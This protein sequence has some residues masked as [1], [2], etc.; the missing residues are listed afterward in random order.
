M[1]NFKFNLVILIKLIGLSL[2]V[3]SCATKKDRDFQDFDSQ[4]IE[5]GLGID[6]KTLAKFRVKKVATGEGLSKRKTKWGD[7]MLDCHADC[8]CSYFCGGFSS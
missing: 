7:W 3:L 4:E 6:Q 2:L 8:F 5:G 1:N